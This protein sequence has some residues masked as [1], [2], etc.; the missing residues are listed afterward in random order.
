MNE[1]TTFCVVVANDDT[2]VVVNAA[3]VTGP[4]DVTSGI[5][6]PGIGGVVGEI[7]STGG[8]NSVGG[9][10]T[11]LNVGVSGAAMFVA[12]VTGTIVTPLNVVVRGVVVATNVGVV[13]DAVITLFPLNCDATGNAVK[14]PP[15]KASATTPIGTS[16]LININPV[17]PRATIGSPLNSSVANCEIC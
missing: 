6:L 17:T 13:I 9:V 3:P 10:G 7:G 16:E 5:A 8:G 4:V 11:P 2:G 14:V 12:G 15:L 1:E